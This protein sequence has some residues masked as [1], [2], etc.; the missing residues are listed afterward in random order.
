MGRWFPKGM[1]A[2]LALL[3]MFA[4]ATETYAQSQRCDQL[5]QTLR[6]LDRN[7]DYR[8][9]QR[10]ASQLRDLQAQLQRDESLF[11]RGGCQQMLQAN[12]QL[13]RECRLVARRITSNRADYDKLARSAE[14]GQAVANQ[15][16]AV[17]QEIARFQCNARS[18]S[19]ARFNNPFD[20]RQ[21]PADNRRNLFERLFDALTGNDDSFF[22]QRIDDSNAWRYG[23]GSTLRTVCVRTCD[24]Y[25]WPV[26]FST[27][28]QFLDQDSASCQAQCPGQEVELYYYHNPGEDA[29]QMVSLNGAPYS[30]L[31]NAFRYRREY[32]KACTCKAPLNYG[33]IEV[34]LSGEGDQRPMIAFEDLKFPLPL[35]DPRG[36]RADIVVAVEAVHVPLPRPRPRKPGEPEPAV[37]VQTVDATIRE[38]RFG[39]RVVRLVGPDTPYVPKA[40]AKS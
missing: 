33:L 2:L 30:S 36:R 25:Y 7:R 29:E 38:V 19:N 40:A 17:L 18:N 15:R 1:I 28:S 31:P 6:T 37:P 16:E 3:A 5:Q 10:N 9:F 23:G 24:G 11:V 22:D 39:D 13:S 4:G 27:V 34:D 35:P 8:N 20:E 32:D 14:T 12:Q 26:S 21:A